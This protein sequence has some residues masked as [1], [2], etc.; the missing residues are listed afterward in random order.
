MLNQLENAYKFIIPRSKFVGEDRFP[1]T[2]ERPVSLKSGSSLIHKNEFFSTYPYPAFPIGVLKKNDTCLHVI[3]NADDITPTMYSALS[4]SPDQIVL[5]FL[6]SNKEIQNQLKMRGK[7]GMLTS[8]L[9]GD[10]LENLASIS[11]DIKKQIKK[12]KVISGQKIPKLNSKI[13]LIELDS[14]EQVIPNLDPEILNAKQTIF[15]NNSG[16]PGL[17]DKIVR[18]LSS[19]GLEVKRW[20]SDVLFFSKQK[21]RSQVRRQHETGYQPN[22]TQFLLRKHIPLSGKTLPSTG[23]PKELMNKLCPILLENRVKNRDEKWKPRDGE[24]KTKEGDSVIVK[25]LKSQKIRTKFIASTPN[26]D[27]VEFGSIEGP[28]TSGQW[29]EDLA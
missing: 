11:S 27:S 5:W 17:Q 10:L 18:F 7:I 1:M 3:V 20:C 2:T 21:N 24:F 23:A 4:H 9:R 8:Y 25:S 12:S 6:N 13:H 26:G 16:F 15:D 28:H 19:C 29:L 14:L 22:L